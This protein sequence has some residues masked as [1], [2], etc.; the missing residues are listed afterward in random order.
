MS[1]LERDGSERSAGAAKAAVPRG[2]QQLLGN[3][4]AGRQT[5]AVLDDGGGEVVAI[6]AELVAQVMSV[7]SVLAR[8]ASPEALVSA[9]S[10]T[11]ESVLM[12]DVDAIF[13]PEFKLDPLALFRQFSHGRA[14]FVVWPGSVDS[15]RLIYSRPGRAD[16][17]DQPALD[18]IILKPTRSVFPDEAPYELERFST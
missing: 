11:S 15:G 18:L 10:P 4:T 12:T 17:F 14:L 7:G 9:I 5:F 6:V 2:W 3:L 16:Y 13:S 1:D 8:L